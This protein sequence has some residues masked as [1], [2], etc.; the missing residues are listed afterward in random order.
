MCATA[1]LDTCFVLLEYI[2][3]DWVYIDIPH[4][5]KCQEVKH[6]YLSTIKPQSPLIFP[7][8]GQTFAA[9]MYCP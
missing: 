3:K 9:C 6:Y 4:P 2:R 7:P 5:N 1:L 8:K